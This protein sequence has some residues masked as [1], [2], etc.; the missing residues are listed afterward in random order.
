MRLSRS[1]MAEVRW[2]FACSACSIVYTTKVLLI[3]TMIPYSPEMP[4]GWTAVNETF[5]CPA[6]EVVIQDKDMV[7]AS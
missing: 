1:P 7:Q 2:T 3:D 6:H 5:F 4:E